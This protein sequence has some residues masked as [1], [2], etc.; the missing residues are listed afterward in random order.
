MNKIKVTRKRNKH[1]YNNMVLIKKAFVTI[2]VVV[3]VNYF[4]LCARAGPTPQQEQELL[5]L[6]A[7]DRRQPI[8]NGFSSNSIMDMLGRSMFLCV[9]GITSL[10]VWF[11]C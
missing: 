1:F 11:I 7:L 6:D 8:Y 2:V 5:L 9:R 4:L 10:K 3:T